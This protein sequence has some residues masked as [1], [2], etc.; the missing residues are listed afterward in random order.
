MSN[1]KTDYKRFSNMQPVNQYDI[2][3]EQADEENDIIKLEKSKK[4]N[5]II[6]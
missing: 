1:K 3:N 4:V 5:K 6:L 2:I